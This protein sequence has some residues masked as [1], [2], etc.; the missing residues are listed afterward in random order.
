ME[1][2][3]WSDG[4]FHF[5]IIGEVAD[6]KISPRILMRDQTT[7]LLDCDKIHKKAVDIIFKEPNLRAICSE[8]FIGETN[9][10]IQLITE[11]NDEL[12][13]TS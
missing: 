5:N 8:F 6:S 3:A 11:D 2:V 9:I 12:K 1:N 4:R 13:P 10:S 7:T